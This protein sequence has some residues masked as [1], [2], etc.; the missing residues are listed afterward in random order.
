MITEN[1]SIKIQLGLKRLIDITIGSLVIILLSPFLLI[2]A[3]LIKWDS[4]GPV[5]YRHRRVGKDGH[6]FDLYKFR[7]MVTG[8]DDSSYMNYL[9]ELIDSSNNKTEAGLPYIKMKDDYRVTKV[10]RVLRKYYLDELPQM[11]NVIKGDLSLVGPRPHV[12]FE[13]DNYTPEQRR[14]LTVKPGATGLWQTVGKADCTFCE[15]LA[16]D[17]EYINSWSLWLDIK[18]IF[19]TVYIMLRGGESFWSR[20]DKKIPRRLNFGLPR[21]KNHKAIKKLDA[22]LSEKVKSKA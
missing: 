18:I 16:Y 13:V 5:I 14:R 6:P 2:I 7:T 9:R 3:I 8:G 20:T 15:L 21:I 19:S 1:L 12:Q 10:G 17:L 11:V 4:T 22:S